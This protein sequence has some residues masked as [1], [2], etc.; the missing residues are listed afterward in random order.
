MEG[1]GEK[2][3]ENRWKVDI[4]KGTFKRHIGKIMTKGGV[5]IAEGRRWGL[6][7][8][9][10]TYIRA[11]RASQRYSFKQDESNDVLARFEQ[12][13]LCG[14]FL[15]LFS[16]G[17]SFK[18]EKNERV[19][20]GENKGSEKLDRNRGDVRGALREWNRVCTACVRKVEIYFFSSISFIYLGRNLSV[21]I[22]SIY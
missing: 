8:G 9:K 2:W 6:A 14:K 17:I 22:R 11:V 18:F 1:R 20:R 12:K 19:H 7:R 5:G 13:I 3:I 21:S 16:L 4:S 10:N 15:H